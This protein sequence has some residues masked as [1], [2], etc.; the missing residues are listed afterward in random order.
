MVTTFPPN[1]VAFSAAYWATFPEPEIT[2]VFPEKLSP[3]VAN[4][5]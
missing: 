3:L 4:I 2:T 5:L 1:W